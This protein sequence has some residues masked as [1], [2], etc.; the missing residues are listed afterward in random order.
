[1]I[2]ERLIFACFY[3]FIIAEQSF[4]ENS[5]FK[6]GGNKKINYLGTVS[7]GLYCYHGIVITLFSKF[8]ELYGW[9]R[10]AWH[11][12]ILN[13]I[14]AFVLTIV[15]ALLSYE[16]FEKKFLKLKYKYY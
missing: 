16:W 7:F 5:L 11:V 6:L 1:M 12:F 8:G 2:P 10:S 3:G 15:L 13:P 9:D 4:A 14:I